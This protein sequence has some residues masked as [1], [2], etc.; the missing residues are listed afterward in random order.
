MKTFLTSSLRAA[1][2]ASTLFVFVTTASAKNTAADRA[3]QLLAR[4][5][6]VEVSAIGD[7]V[8]IGTFLIQV[9][10]TLGAPDN[11]LADG[12]WLY[13]RKRI[14]NSEAQG[15]LVVRFTNGRVSSLTLATPAVV[16]ALRDAPS[17]NKTKNLVASQQHR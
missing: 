1:A 10:V 9:S 3:E 12:T 15:T 2:L 17:P 4:H 16:A 7:Y 5:G 8:E 14:E 13:S 6:S 11:K